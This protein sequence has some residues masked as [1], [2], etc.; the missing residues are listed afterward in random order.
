MENNPNPIPCYFH[1]LDSCRFLVDRCDSHK[2]VSRGL[3]NYNLLRCGR[4]AE[5]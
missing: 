5:G 4:L 1:L 2:T 3:I